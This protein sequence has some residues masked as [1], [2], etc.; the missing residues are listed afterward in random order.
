MHHLNTSAFD[1]AVVSQSSRAC[2]SRVLPKRPGLRILLSSSPTVTLSPRL[3]FES[4]SRVILR[5]CKGPRGT[6]LQ[7]TVKLDIPLL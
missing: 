7:S 2:P 3:L 4:W 5:S 6:A 1:S